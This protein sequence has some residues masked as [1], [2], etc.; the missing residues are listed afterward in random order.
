MKNIIIIGANQGIGKG[1][2]QVLSKQTNTNLIVTSRNYS[3]KLTRSDSLWKI[4][5]DIS[6]EESMQNFVTQVSAQFKNIDGII[7]CAGLLHTK[8]YFP[9]KTLSKINPM[10][11]FENYQINAIGHLILLQKMERLIAASKKP[12]VTSISARIG[13]IKD[14]QLGGWYS[15]RMSKAALNMGYKTLEIE[16]RRKYPHIRLLL[17]HPGTTNTKLSKP[18]QKRLKIGMLQSVEQTS[19]FIIDQINKKLNGQ[20]IPLFVDFKGIQIEW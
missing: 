5:C 9:E 13:S 16:W 14:N 10:Q 8:H 12:I 20:L 7:N 17:I 19:G 18:F 4:Q 3:N 2:A 11:M 1:L 15:Y 6:S